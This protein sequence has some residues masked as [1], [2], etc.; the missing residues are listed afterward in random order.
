MFYE[1]CMAC[2]CRARLGVRLDILFPFHFLWLDRL[3]IEQCR[4]RRRRFLY[5]RFCVLN[6]F[7]R[8]LGEPVEIIIGQL[9]RL[10]EWDLGFIR[11]R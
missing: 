9:K 8:D 1:R 7:R 10:T 5:Q 3:G 11:R 6:I 4:Q 2:G